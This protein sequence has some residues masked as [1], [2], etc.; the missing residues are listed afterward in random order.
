MDQHGKSS[1]GI[2]WTDK[3]RN[4]VKLDVHAHLKMVIKK[5]ALDQKCH[6]AFQVVGYTSYQTKFDGDAL[7]TKFHAN[8]YTHGGPWYDW[9][10]IQFHQNDIPASQSMSPA[11]IIGFVRYE[12]RG[13]PT[14]YLIQDDGVTLEEIEESNMEDETMYAIIHTASQWLTMDT[15]ESEFSET[16]LLGDVNQCLYIVDVKTIIAPLFVVANEN[17]LTMI[18]MLPKKKWGKFFDR[19]LDEL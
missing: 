10:M 11:K 4:K 12:S 3:K 19:C 1:V 6:G 18:C 5:F 8:E 14:P 2:E 15:L 7:H 16:F 13:I 17:D 9:G